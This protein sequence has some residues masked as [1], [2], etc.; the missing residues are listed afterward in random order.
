M[1]GILIIGRRRRSP[2]GVDNTPSRSCWRSTVRTDCRLALSAVW[3]AERGRER[4]KRGHLGNEFLSRM[5]FTIYPPTV[6]WAGDEEKSVLVVVRPS[7][8]VIVAVVR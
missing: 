4:S 2:W 5:I 7:T 1:R 3:V 8:F 6:K